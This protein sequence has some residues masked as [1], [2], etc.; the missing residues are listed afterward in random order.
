MKR[1]DPR[2]PECQVA[3]DKRT[4]CEVHRELY[5]IIVLHFKTS[6]HFEEITNRL[7]EAYWMGKRMN[8]K[9]R[10][11]KHNYDDGWWEQISKQMRTERQ[12][13]R[14]RT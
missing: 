1:D 10:Q 14:N 8:A 12:G 4:I 5:D 7:E 6:P 2:P 9:L 11:Y 13:L 3:G